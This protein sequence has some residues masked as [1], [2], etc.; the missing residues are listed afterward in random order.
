VVINEP[1][2]A[3]KIVAESSDII[4]QIVENISKDNNIKHTPNQPKYGI[5]TFGNGKHYPLYQPNIIEI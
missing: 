5:N 4:V 2:N 3:V 1:K